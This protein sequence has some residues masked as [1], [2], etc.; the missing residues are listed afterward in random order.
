MKLSS[1][2]LN[3]SENYLDKLADKLSVKF[4]HLRFYVKFGER[5][6]VRGSQ[7]DL[8][9]FG[10]KY[11]GQKFGDYEVFHVDDDDQGEIVRIVKLK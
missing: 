4:P 3:E 9:G 6:D 11:H 10:D 7:Q 1:I 2:L 5:I 8:L